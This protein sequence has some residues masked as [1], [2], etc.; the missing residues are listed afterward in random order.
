MEDNQNGGNKKIYIAI[1]A[2]L[3]LINGV[4]LY[5][6][7]S[8]NKAKKDLGDQKIA[9]ENEFKSMTDTLDAKKME[10]EQYKGKNAELDSIITAKQEEIEQQKKTISGLFARGKMDKAE[11]EK[12]RTMMGQYEQSIAELQKKVDEMVQQNQQL[13][14]QNQQLSTDLNSEKQNSSTLA[15]QNKGLS[16]K[17]ELGSLLQ[18]RNMEVVGVSS[19]KNKKG[20]DIVMTK[21]KKTEQLRISFETGDNKVLEPGPVSLYIRLV[22][23]KGET[24]SVADQGSGTIKLAESG[25]E[26]QFTKKAD[27]DWSQNNKKLVVYWSSNVSD[28]GTYKVEVYQSGYMVGQGTA[29]LK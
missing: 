14:A 25:E 16:K 26:V 6:L 18:L 8:E 21:A 2:L 28:A 23:P 7:Y 13:N 15:E 11:L 24:V 1:I 9:L 29:I 10:L 22:N 17:V 20:E 19:K 12:A 5:L 3:L 4:A 27:F